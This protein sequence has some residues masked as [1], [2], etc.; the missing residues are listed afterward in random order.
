MYRIYRHSYLA[1]LLTLALL[2]QALSPS[3]AMASGST[4]SLICN[5]A[6]QLSI[7]MQDSLKELKEALGIVD[8]LDVNLEMDCEDCVVPFVFI[9]TSQPADLVDI[10]WSAFSS[11]L[12][13]SPFLITRPRGPPLGSRAPPFQT[14][15]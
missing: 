11:P 12:R 10:K 2:I 9:Q 8:Q 14:V 4:H 15:I 13:P 1:V 7:E 3:F 6:D 5:P